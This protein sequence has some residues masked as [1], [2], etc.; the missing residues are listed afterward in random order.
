MKCSDL[1]A[2][3][4]DYVD[5]VAREAEKATVELHIFPQQAHVLKGDAATVIGFC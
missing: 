1:E 4:C 3:I 5:G 2:L